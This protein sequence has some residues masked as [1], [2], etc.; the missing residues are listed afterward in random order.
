MQEQVLSHRCLIFLE[1]LVYFYCRSG[2]FSEDTIW[3]QHP[4]E[5]CPEELTE[6][7][8]VTNF[9]LTDGNDPVSE[10]HNQLIRYTSR[11]LTKPDIDAIYAF[12]GILTRLAASTNSGLLC[13]LLTSAFDIC[14]L[15]W[16]PRFWQNNQGE[17]RRRPSFPSW[18]WAGWSGVALLV[19]PEDGSDQKHSLSVNSEDIIYNVYGLSSLTRGVTH[20]GTGIA[21][22][23]VRPVWGSNDRARLGPGHSGDNLNTPERDYTSS[24]DSV[25]VNWNAIPRD[26]EILYF[27]ALTIR[28]FQMRLSKFGNVLVWPRTSDDVEEQDDSSYPLLASLAAGNFVPSDVRLYSEELG[29]GQ[30]FDIVLLSRAERHDSFHLSW[31]NV[32]NVNPWDEA[33]AG[34]DTKPDRPVIWALLVVRERAHFRCEDVEEKIQVFYERRALGFIYQDRLKEFEGIIKGEVILA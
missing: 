11:D 6:A 15:F 18:S 27:H 9:L 31:L 1:N 22:H 16:H 13:G 34:L 2:Y 17:A 3:D 28:S 8:V 5:L 23:T 29:S 12:L 26:Y 20:G 30:E 7:S 21:H 14:L 32:G 25:Q 19:I 33:E 24:A 10:Y 4:T